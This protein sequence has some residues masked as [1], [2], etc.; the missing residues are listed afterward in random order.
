MLQAKS[1][2]KNTFQEFMNYCKALD[3]CKVLVR[4]KNLEHIGHKMEQGYNPTSEPWFQKCC[5]GILMLTGDVDMGKIWLEGH[6]P[7]NE[8]IHTWFY[9]AA[10]VTHVTYDLRHY[11]NLLTT[12][13]ISNT[14]H[15]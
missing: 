2:D 6:F 14:Q 13:S 11:E 3:F 10:D 1:V 5:K 12:S 4:V 9:E 7:Y 15:N 8:T